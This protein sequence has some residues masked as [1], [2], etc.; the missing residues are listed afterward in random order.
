MLILH[1]YVSVPPPPISFAPSLGDNAQ[2]GVGWGGAGCVYGRSPC[3]GGVSPWGGGGGRFGLRRIVLGSAARSPGSPRCHSLGGEGGEAT[4]QITP[5]RYSMRVW[6]NPVFPPP[7]DRIFVPYTTRGLPPCS[8]FVLKGPSEWAR[9]P[10]LS[11][12]GWG[13]PRIPPS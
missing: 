9:G 5:E 4:A 11:L 10:L 12:G 13:P 2:G 1:V 7:W 3:F 6:S 8:L